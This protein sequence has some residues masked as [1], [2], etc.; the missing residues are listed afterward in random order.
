[1]VSAPLYALG[2]HLPVICREFAHEA[3]FFTSRLVEGKPS[4]REQQWFED[5]LKSASELLKKSKFPP[6]LPTEGVVAKGGVGPAMR[7]VRVGKEKAF[8]LISRHAGPGDSTNHYS[9]VSAMANLLERRGIPAKVV[10]EP[11]S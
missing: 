8:E 10:H 2:K 9:R 7:L 3:N 1:M 6:R 11:R 5:G 4:S